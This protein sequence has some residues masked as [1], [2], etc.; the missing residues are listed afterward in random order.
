MTSKG[1]V[2]T[3]AA[4]LVAGTWTIDPAHTEVGF[5]IRH[6]MA[7]VRG[8]FNDVDGTIVV[9]ETA[10]ASKVSVE[11][12]ASSV[13]TRNEQRDGHLRSAEIL[14]VEK[15]PVLTFTST[16]LR[17][18]GDDYVLDGDL[19]VTDVTRSVSLAVEFNGT[20]ID[21]WGGLRAGFSATTS[22]SRKDYGV[23][24]NIPLPG[25]DKSLLGDKV[26]ITIEV[27]AVLQQDEQA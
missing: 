20:G 24:F 19:T 2:D 15:Y 10:E 9:G 3:A 22:I 26:E 8:A 18:D 11:I 6:L 4:G 27:E 25:G 14:D 23:D 17:H 5:A 7:K 12:Q 13:D 1:A 16:G 21:P